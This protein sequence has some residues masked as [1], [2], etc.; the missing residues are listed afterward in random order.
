MMYKSKK[1]RK[2]N[3]NT[4]TTIFDSALVLKS[5][6][7]KAELSFYKEGGGFLNHLELSAGEKKLS[8]LASFSS[9]EDIKNNYP[10][11]CTNLF[12]FPNRLRDGKYSFEGKEYQFPINEKH[13]QNNLHGFLKELVPSA[14]LKGTDS[15]QPTLHTRYSYDGAREYYPFPAEVDVDYS[16]PSSSELLVTFSVKNT[17]KTSMPV[18][19]G[20]HPYFDLGLN[21]DELDMLFPECERVLIDERMIPTGKTAAYANFNKWTRIG[22]TRLDDCFIPAKGGVDD[23]AVSVWSEK[24]AAGIEVWQDKNFGFIQVYTPPDR[25]SIAIE[26]MSCNIN[27]FQSKDGLSVLSPGESFSGKF[28]VRMLTTK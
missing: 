23:V 2:A 4:M 22:D 24:H 8:V 14:Q 1:K 20:W 25:Q 19:V 6:D 11:R 15:N 18:G 9:L 13:N 16:L 28:G 21:I 27:A 17:G 5:A 10:F 12:P 7:G 3:T 26:P